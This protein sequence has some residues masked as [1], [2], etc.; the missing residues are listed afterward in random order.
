[1]SYRRIKTLPGQFSLEEHTTRPVSEYFSSNVNG[2]GDNTTA[3]STSFM[4]FS[5]HFSPVRR[6]RLEIYFVA[7]IALYRTES[8]DHQKQCMKVIEEQDLPHSPLTE[9]DTNN[10]RSLL[11][12]VCYTLLGTNEP[13]VAFAAMHF[14]LLVGSMISSQEAPLGD[15]Q[16]VLRPLLGLWARHEGAKAADQFE[17]ADIITL[18]EE[19]IIEGSTVNILQPTMRLIVDFC[20]I[21]NGNGSCPERVSTATDSNWWDKLQQLKNRYRPNLDDLEYTYEEENVELGIYASYMF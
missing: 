7:L 2:P 16:S 15:R 11:E 9:L 17:L 8:K 5:L 21:D 3:V 6:S 10:G 1:M 18:L 19:G 4:F 13:V 20:H 12:H 14:G